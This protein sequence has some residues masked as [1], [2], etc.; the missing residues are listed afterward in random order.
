M[1]NAARTSF[2]SLQDSGLSSRIA[3]SEEIYQRMLK[4]REELLNKFGPN[5]R[6]IVM[7]VP[8]FTSA[9]PCGIE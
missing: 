5:P 2:H 4:G 6:D 1:L 3:K 8:F 7:F 9:S